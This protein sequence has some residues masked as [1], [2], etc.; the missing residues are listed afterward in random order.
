M[1]AEHLFKYGDTIPYIPLTLPAHAQVCLQIRL[2]N[3]LQPCEFLV[4]KEERTGGKKESELAKNFESKVEY[5][6]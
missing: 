2:N 1:D 3:L 6:S 4:E 5:I